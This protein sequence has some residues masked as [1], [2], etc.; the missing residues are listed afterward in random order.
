MQKETREPRVE[1]YEVWLSS[2][3][4][5]LFFIFALTLDFAINVSTVFMKF[6]TAITT[7]RMPQTIT[8]NMTTIDKVLNI[9]VTFIHV[10][11]GLY[12]SAVEKIPV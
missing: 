6:P 5:L 2:A 3:L 1:N 12:Q 10:L 11:V 4:L 8:W 7:R 9:S